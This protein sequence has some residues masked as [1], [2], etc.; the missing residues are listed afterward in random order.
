MHKEVNTMTKAT[1]R[2]AKGLLAGVVVGT[3]VSA[4]TI[5]SMKPKPS[6]MLRK[7]AAKAL[8]TMG[9]VMMNIADYTK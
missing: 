6:K 1:K 9:S 7:K 5:I 3:A 2:T 8:D 4:A